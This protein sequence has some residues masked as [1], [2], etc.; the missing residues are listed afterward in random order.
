M[1]KQIDTQVVEMRF[2][3]KQF[4]EEAKKTTSTLERLEKKINELAE[5]QFVSGGMQKLSDA[6]QKVEVKFSAL[7]KVAEGALTSIGARAEQAGEQ[8]VRSLTVDQLTAGWDKYNE[9]TR[10]V[11]QIMGATGDSIETVNEYLEKLMWFTDETSYNF[12]DMTSNIGKFTSQGIKLDKATTAMIGIANWAAKAG[13]GVNEASRAMYNLSQALGKGYV[14]LIDWNSIINA[15]MDTREFKE[16]VL[17]NAVAL[18]T[19]SEGFKNAKGELVTFQ[20]FGEHLNEGFFTTDVLMKTLQEYGDYTELVYKVVQETGVSASEAMEAL[21]GMYEGVGE[22]AFKAGQEAKTF[23]D[24]IDATKDA[25]S[26]G[27]L[28]TFEIIFGNYEEAKVLWTDLANGLWEVFNGG[29]EGRNDLLKEWKELGGREELIEGLTNAAQDLLAILDMLGDAWDKAFPELTATKLYQWT[30]SFNNLMKNLHLTEFASENL[31]DAI[32]GLLSIFRAG[33]Q[34]IGAFLG[35]TGGL[36]QTAN[37]LAGLFVAIAGAIGRFLMSLSDA[38]TTQENLNR[39]TKAS[40]LIFGLL[41]NTFETLKMIVLGV[42]SVFVSAFDKFDFT[43]K[44]A[45]TGVD[46]FFGA[47]GQG[48]KDMATANG[49]AEDSPIFKLLE[50]IGAFFTAIKDAIETPIL[51]IG[52]VL[53]ILEDV[54]AQTQKAD[55]IFDAL[56][57]DTGLTDG[58]TNLGEGL[59]KV[60]DEAGDFL[61]TIEPIGSQMKKLLDRLK[62]DL[63]AALGYVMDRLNQASLTDI[64]DS[65]FVL[66]IAGLA[67]DLK[68]ALKDVKEIATAFVKPFQTVADS[69]SKTLTTLQTNIKISSMKGLAI[70]LAILAGSLIALALVPWQRLVPAG[71]AMAALTAAIVILMKTMDKLTADDTVA[72]KFKSISTTLMKASVLM[73]AIGFALSKIGKNDFTKQLGAVISM[74][75]VMKATTTMMESLSKTKIDKSINKTLKQVTKAIT[76]LMIPMFIIGKMNP[77]TILQG[78]AVMGAMALGLVLLTSAFAT[79]NQGN[80]FGDVAGTFTKLAI[81]LNLLIIPLMAVT[82]IVAKAEWNNIVAALEI[83]AL[84]IAALT[85]SAMLL[86]NTAPQ[87]VKTATAFILM[88]TA[89][90]MLIIPLAALTA[91]NVSGN[92]GDA[93]VAFTLLIAVITAATAALSFL[94]PG[95]LSV[96]GGFALLGV[97]I[98]AVVLSFTALLSVILAATDS[99]PKLLG[100]IVAFG[101]VSKEQISNAMENIKLAVNGM[102]DVII[103]VLPRVIGIVSEL[104]ASV[105]MT[106]KL[107]MLRGRILLA[108][109]AVM[110]IVSLWPKIKEAILAL[111]GLIEPFLASV[112]EDHIKPFLDEQG[113]KIKEWIRY[114]FQSLFLLIGEIVITGIAFA[115]NPLAGVIVGALGSVFNIVR[116][117]AK[118]KS[119][120]IGEDAV[121]GTVEGVEK[122]GE[123][124]EDAM[125]NVA[126]KGVDA[127]GKGLTVNSPGK[128]EFKQG[129]DAVSG[130]ILG[131]FSQEDNLWDTFNNLGHISVE[132]HGEGLGNDKTPNGLG[133]NTNEAL[134]GVFKAM[135]DIF[136]DLELESFNLGLFGVANP[137]GE[138]IDPMSD[139]MSEELQEV[140]NTLTGGAMEGAGEG[141]GNAFVSGVGNSGAGGR[142]A[143]SLAKGIDEDDSIEKAAKEKAEKVAK[144]F[145]NALSHV[146]FEQSLIDSKYTIADA[147]LGPKDTPEKAMKQEQYKLTRMQEEI[148]QL[149]NKYQISLDKYNEIIKDIKANGEK[150]TYSAQDLED[151]YSQMKSDEAAMFEKAADI[152]E[153]QFQQT[154][155]YEE[156]RKTSQE[157]IFQMQREQATYQ[158]QALQHHEEMV[159]R[160]YNKWMNETDAELRS[161]LKLQYIQLKDMSTKD[162]VGEMPTIDYT[163]IMKD[164]FKELGINPDDPTTSFMDVEDIVR[165]T[166][167]YTGHT[168]QEALEVAYSEL[169]P[170]ATKTV[171]AHGVDAIM[172]QIDAEKPN[173]TKIGAR[174]GG[175]IGDGVE[176]SE[177]HIVE[178]AVWV[179]RDAQQEVERV[180]PPEWEL[181]G[182]AMMDG[183]ARG[184][185]D[186]KSEVINAAVEVAMAALSAAKSFLGI[187][188][189]SKVFAEVGGNIVAGLSLGMDDNMQLS[190]NSAEGLSENVINSFKTMNQQIENLLNYDVDPTITPV[191]DLS[192]IRSGVSRINRLMGGTSKTYAG[193]ISTAEQ[194]REY[195]SNLAMTR[196]K[197]V[198]PSV[199]NNYSF[200]QNNTSPKAL[201]AIEIYRQTH[202]Q[203]TW[204]FTRGEPR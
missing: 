174:M 152:A 39:I 36:F 143:K 42:G 38:I 166:M 151:A 9:K 180:S 177:S 196:A 100:T 60:S 66:G 64:A 35:G 168:Y 31:S 201:S 173:Y 40:N 185:R 65:L 129:S 153:W 182:V 192:N 159:E 144:I 134:A 62:G 68:K 98:A 15:G 158:A 51:A 178:E 127:H 181:V 130:T 131:A 119:M 123:E 13:G 17:E 110:L 70:S 4:E 140:I 14:Q 6:V 171:L 76:G 113:E 186:G 125:E 184:I 164:T 67:N 12:V 175:Y 176:D 132:A 103:G 11:S 161:Q 48:F 197:T 21:E 92:L 194:R 107:A 128:T 32:G 136:P 94:G 97:G 41:F 59:A 96:G 195:E 163:K 179:S 122:K 142:A 198:V 47:V 204:A 167:E 55:G 54:N 69:I 190:T 187:E 61:K 149:G 18:G 116:G 139:K 73:I 189:P 81:A 16:A 154:E 45:K 200:T 170:E 87:V 108:I 50:K 104:I 95:I 203:L 124:L 191:M 146:S 22:S 5:S 75:A 7:S 23:A 10:S 20:N 85:M 188:S 26:S 3:N 106:V 33:G 74:S 90:N 44:G 112:Y 183:L 155:K 88:A 49:I 141:A 58:L 115:I 121:E 148:I 102:L 91:L 30:Q 145:E 83:M 46:E 1:S 162:I 172:D 150:S 77:Q 82:A 117:F 99:L 63:D 169:V 24:A 165:Q 28:D 160:A 72:E 29:A 27:W 19:L 56:T 156:A 133:E 84:E 89:I 120:N 43:L 34:V 8:M 147:L 118:K 137:F 53:G 138:G 135:Q 126:E 109:E 2:D 52:R 25:V 105:W 79:L 93:V 57:V 80:E 101:L 199:T 114:F 193:R 86:S 37:Q 157:K 78:A 111:W 71:L 202:N